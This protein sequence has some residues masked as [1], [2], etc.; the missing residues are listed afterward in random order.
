MSRM[1][2]R[3]PGTC[4]KTGAAITPSEM[5]AGACFN[6][7]NEGALRVVRGEV[8]SC[9]DPD[10]ARP[11][12]LVQEYDEGRWQIVCPLTD[13]YFMVP[14]CPVRWKRA[15]VALRDMIERGDSVTLADELKA[16]KQ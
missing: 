5:I 3:Y 9:M 2:A 4:R 14:M 11:G 6:E 15:S 8:T 12:L 7:P 1:T 10:D 16:L 13:A